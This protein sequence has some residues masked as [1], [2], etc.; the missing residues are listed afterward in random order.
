MKRLIIALCIILTVFG[1]YFLYI[2]YGMMSHKPIEN[3]KQ[4]DVNEHYEIK[5]MQ[6]SKV[7]DFSE[8]KM[9]HVD[10]RSFFFKR[11]KEGK[12]KIYAK[13]P[14]VYQERN[15]IAEKVLHGSVVNMGIDQSLFT[16]KKIDV[17]V[18][19]EKV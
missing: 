6:G 8:I 9:T 4:A 12:C 18:D 3:M 2:L 5:F 17:Y 11:Q 19:G 1:L 13:Y 10:E 14:A 16:T 15:V 7:S